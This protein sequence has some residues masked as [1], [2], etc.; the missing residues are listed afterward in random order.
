MLVSAASNS[1]SNETRLFSR[2]MKVIPKEESLIHSLRSL[3]PSGKVLL[4]AGATVR[5]N[6][7]VKNVGQSGQFNFK[8]SQSLPLTEYRSR[9]FN[10]SVRFLQ[11][12]PP[13]LSS[14]SYLM[15]FKGAQSRLNGLKSLAK[16]F[17]FIVCNPC[18]S[19][20]SLT[21]LVPLWFII[22][23]LMFF[24]LCSTIFRFPSIQR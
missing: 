21:I 2:D 20:P 9:L 7:T 1:S 24:C 19:S 18:E 13:F 12:T 14:Y 3:V 8:V 23:S 10:H 15:Y 17:N 4:N 6:F 5:V 16:L 22:T 11:S